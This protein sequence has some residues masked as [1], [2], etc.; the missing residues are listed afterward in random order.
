M[1]PYKLTF[2]NGDVLGTTDKSLVE[3]L[4]KNRTKVKKA[5]VNSQP[6]IVGDRPI[7]PLDYCERNNFKCIRGLSE[8]PN[9]KLVLISRNGSGD[10][11]WLRPNGQM[12]AMKNSKSDVSGL[13]NLYDE[14][15]KEYK[16]EII[17]KIKEINQFFDNMPELKKL[18]D[19]KYSRY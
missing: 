4:I 11:S 17:K 18:Y 16:T 10:V 8:H 7:R 3:D 6:V 14:K 15:L 1:Y 13:I 9:G 2:S 5:F 19:T 12:N